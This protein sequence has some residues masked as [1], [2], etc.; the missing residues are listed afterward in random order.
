MKKIFYKILVFFLLVEIFTLHGQP[1][2]SEISGKAGSF[3]RLGF[4][5]RGMGMGN[6]MSTIT[7]GNL[8]S[9]YN[10]ALSAFQ[11]GNSFQTSYS[12]LSL[13]RTLNF[14]NFTKR[15]E[16]SKSKS[17]GSKS[18]STAGIS[19]GLIN[20]GVSKIDVRDSQGIKTGEVSTSEN[21]FFLGVANKFS[22]KFAIGL[23]FKFYYFK[24]FEGLSS[25]G[26]GFDIG[27]LYLLNNNLTLSFVLTDINSAYNWDTGQ[28]YGTAGNTTKNTFPLLKKI[29]ASYNFK[30]YGL[31]IAVEY[32][33]SNAKTNYLRVG[34]E[35]NIYQ[36]FYLRAGI[37]KIDLSNFDVPIRP[38]LGFSYFYL[39]NSF[40]IG[41]DYAFIIEPYSSSD[42][43]ILGINLIF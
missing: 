14:V 26:F 17:D 1:K 4:G 28:I 27:L 6:A 30:E 7:T 29:G 5:A 42:S 16:F 15:F 39:L 34:T 35:Y 31:I 36:N 25:T 19:I 33:N 37:D 40:K 12:F 23:A 41:V 22:D 18:R 32:E 13:D 10:P 43:H 3:S 8:S 21:Q 2:F 11:E 20:A 38:S 9:Y 24:L